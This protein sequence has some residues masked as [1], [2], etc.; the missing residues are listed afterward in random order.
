MFGASLI[1]REFNSWSTRPNPESELWQDALQKKPKGSIT[2]G[3]LRPHVVE[4]EQGLVT[5]TR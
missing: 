1:S 5:E 3:L 2:L 4:E